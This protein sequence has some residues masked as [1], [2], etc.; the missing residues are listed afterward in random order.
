[1]SWLLIASVVLNIVLAMGFGHAAGQLSATRE[2]EDDDDGGA[3]LRSMV[4]S[5]LLAPTSMIRPF[6]AS[7]RYGQA[8]RSEIFGAVATVGNYV[9]GP[10]CP[11]YGLPVHGGECIR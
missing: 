9:P 7:E 8:T 1:M 3:S 10:V 2:P 5:G 11:K 6:T 4:E